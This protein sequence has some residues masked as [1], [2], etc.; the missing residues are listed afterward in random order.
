MKAKYIFMCIAVAAVMGFTACDNDREKTHTPSSGLFL[1][2]TTPGVYES[3][4]SIYAFSKISDQLYVNT[5]T[6]TYRIVS[7]DGS[8]YVQVALDSSIPGMGEKVTATITSKGI[9]AVGK[10]DPIEFEVM[11][12]DSE[13]CWLW[14]QEKGLGLILFYIP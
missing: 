7:D 1:R 14:S 3:T 8:K 9:E 12:K 2:K 13:N 11:K 6:N 4:K 10:Y 5:S